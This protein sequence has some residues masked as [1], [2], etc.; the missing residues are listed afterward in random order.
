[1]HFDGILPKGSYPPCLR[2]ADRTLLAGYP[3]HVL[4]DHE[5]TF[6]IQSKLRKVGC[7]QPQ[8]MFHLFYS[9]LQPSQ[10]LKA[11][12]G[13]S[14]R[15][16]HFKQNCMLLYGWRLSECVILQ[17]S[18]DSVPTYPKVTNFINQ[19]LIRNLSQHIKH[20]EKNKPKKPKKTQGMPAC[21][22]LVAHETRLLTV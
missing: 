3:R 15:R 2:L 7:L 18:S 21:C 4:Q 1:M 22:T 14:I 16:V 9:M 11:M 10:H 19:W 12:Y 5:S 13:V 20:F 17:V 8:Y 6:A